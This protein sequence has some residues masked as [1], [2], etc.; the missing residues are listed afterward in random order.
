M[1]TSG[2]RSYIQSYNNVCGNEHVEETHNYRQD[3]AVENQH[4]KKYLLYNGTLILTETSRVIFN[5]SSLKY[6][7]ATSPVK[8]LKSHVILLLK[9]PS[10]TLK[11]SIHDYFFIVN[12][13]TTIKLFL[14][15]VALF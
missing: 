14:K 1:G 15:K 4:R 10:T 3:S 13:W 8:N 12:A 9:T 2:Q 5:R 7:F 6:S 11:F